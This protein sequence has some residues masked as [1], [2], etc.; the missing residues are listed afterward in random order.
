MPTNTAS[1]PTDP[2]LLG[3]GE[4][5]TLMRSHDWNNS[6]L[7]NTRTWPTSLRTTLGII[8]NSK[9]PMLL[10]WGPKLICFYNDAY[11]ISL[12]ETGKHPC[13]L[14]KA[15]ED[16]SPEIWVVIKP[17]INQVLNDKKAE[18]RQDQLVPICRNGQLEDSYWTF[19]CSPVIDDIGK[20]GGVLVECHEPTE[21]VKRLKETVEREEQ[22]A[23]ILDAAQLG[24]YDIQL[25]TQKVISNN[26]L[27]E[28][29]GLPPSAEIDFAIAMAVIAEPDRQKVIDTISSVL[30]AAFDSNYEIAFTIINP[31]NKQQ[32]KVLTKGKILFD[33]AGQPY[34]FSGILQDITEQLLVRKKIEENN[35]R[36]RNLVDEAPIAAC[37]YVG[38][39][40]EIE[41]ANAE[42]LKIWGKEKEVIGLHL[43]D[44][45]PELEGQLFYQLLDAVYVSGKPF[46]GTEIKTKLLID[47][48]LQTFYFDIT[49]K[50]LKN[51]KNEITGILHTAIDVTSLV[52]ERKKVADSEKRFRDTVMQAPLG[53][54]IL[55]GTELRVEMANQT[56][57][58]IIDKTEEEAFGNPLLDLLLPQIGNIVGPMLHHVLQSGL[59]YYGYEFEKATYHNGLKKK[60]YLNCIYYPLKETDGSTSG[61]L[62]ILTD[63]TKLVEAKFSLMESE[64]QFRN[65]IINSPVAMT[66]LRGQDCIIEL[67]N[68]VLLKTL[69]HKSLS[70]VQGKKI[71]DV[72]P[73]MA[74]QHYPELLQNVFETGLTYKESEKIAYINE[75]DGTK[76][77]FVDFE[78]TPLFAEDSTVSGIMVTVNNI[79]EMVEAR[80]KIEDAEERT[81]LAIE[82][83]NLGTFEFNLL[84]DE[85]IYSNRFYEIFGLEESK[86]HTKYLNMVHPQDQQIRD[87]AHRIAIKTGLLTYDARIIWKDHSL[88][89]IQID[90]K[91]FYDSNGYAIRMLG[92]IKDIT[93]QKQTEIELKLISD[94]FQ[95]LANSMPQQVWTSDGDG[96]LNYFNEAVFNYSRLSFNQLQKNGW[97]QIIHPQDIHE[98]KKR[99]L[100][101]ITSGNDFLF[102][103]RWLRYDGEY[104]W[105]LSRAVAQ[106]DANGNIQL[107]VGTSTDIHEQKTFAQEME[108]KVMQRTLQ[109]NQSAKELEQLNI[110]LVKSNNELA[111]F[112]Y[113]ASHDLQEPL[114][115]IQ[116]FATRIIETDSHNLS[117]KGND[118]F[119][120]MQSS[121]LRMQQ[122]ILDLLSFSRTNTTE[123]YFKL[124]DLNTIFQTVIEQLK[125]N[126]Q[127]KQAEVSATLLPIIPIIPYQFEQ[128]LTNIINNAL[129]FSKSD[130][131]PTIKICANI[132]AGT[133]IEDATIDH[134]INYHH[135][136]ISDNGIGFEAQFND[137][138]FKM[139]QRLHGKH[140]YEG[141]GIGLA[142]VK[143][144]VE[145]HHG[146]ISA[147]G[148]LNKGA[149]FNIYIPATLL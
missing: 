144:I 27:K 139:F 142:I 41:L 13:I 103:H 90:G 15:A 110:E 8:L 33:K 107:W 93:E 108:E 34:K 97:L 39:G 117:E 92:T 133:S 104:R 32:R 52:I 46:K 25:S 129:K 51:A 137:R 64:K 94:R 86:D 47:N 66:V 31:L 113:V 75:I 61:I 74:E 89:W 72:F 123:K 12:G 20:V 38:E 119:L 125:D 11:R 78:Y 29:F 71:L 114:R 36:Y 105:H 122:L 88:H 79:T 140:E 130:T 102:E 6:L 16:A 120:R 100:Q 85:L 48:S 19:S 87:N 96:D 42:M 10:C 63:V 141:T 4:M 69:W 67:A 77:Y 112:A 70:E 109:L 26:R 118:Y 18:W 128:L 2:F 134:Q 37:V 124:T 98:N 40:M 145:N 81:R 126:I 23:F 58:Q 59:P 21:Q 101:S 65:L 146:T 9:F 99:W 80:K 22:F 83:G 121:A 138:I 49:Y 131:I 3:G 82:G 68:D 116:T 45:L 115:K 132:V 24:T 76:K 147:S 106:R 7:G 28:W 127:L 91:T 50:P 56:Y 57:L 149:T 53:V 14:G 111:Q 5:G 135:I 143:K 54:L 84:T 1:R 17:I 35:Q 60:Q 43:K 95:L 30:T 73:E 148:E 44:A 62:I 55:R 136:S